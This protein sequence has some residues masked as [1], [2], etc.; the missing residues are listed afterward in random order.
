MKVE[1]FNLAVLRAAAEGKSLGTY[2]GSTAALKFWIEA[3]KNL[4]WIDADRVPTELGR[5]VSEELALS[6]QEEGRAYAWRHA[7]QLTEQAGRFGG[8]FVEGR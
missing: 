2:F 1:I 3:T 6:S 7:G 5:R 4:G 8:T